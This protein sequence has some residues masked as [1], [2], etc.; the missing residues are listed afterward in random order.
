M[1]LKTSD[2]HWNLK[3]NTHRLLGCPQLSPWSSRTIWSD[4]DWTAAHPAWLEMWVS[5]VPCAT[6]HP[7]TPHPCWVLCALGS[8]WGPLAP[9]LPTWPCEPNC[10][11]VTSRQKTNPSCQSPA[12]TTNTPELG[13]T[14]YSSPRRTGPRVST[15]CWRGAGGWG[16]TTGSFVLEMMALA[17]REEYFRQGLS[18]CFLGGFF[19][20]FTNKMSE[21][22]CS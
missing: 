12:S 11:Q 18:V 16:H 9:N 5:A 10:C 15:D 2:V 8:P 17:D 22:M 7:P 4:A 21:K 3:I 20:E 19:H 6:P 1:H 13:H 14:F